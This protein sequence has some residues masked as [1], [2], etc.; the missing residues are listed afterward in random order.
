MRFHS[1][2]VR[3]HIVSVENKPYVQT[4]WLGKRKGWRG[5][6]NKALNILSSLFKTTYNIKYK[7]Q[8]RIV[9]LPYK[10]QMNSRFRK[11]RAAW[12]EAA[13]NNCILRY[14]TT[15]RTFMYACVYVGWERC[16]SVTHG[17]LELRK[18]EKMRKEGETHWR[19]IRNMHHKLVYSVYIRR[20]C[21]QW[22]IC[23]STHFCEV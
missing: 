16:Q 11:D 22:R 20:V 3:V 2:H 21:S 9:L 6:E 15:P 8:R 23:Y 1:S 10:P 14:H 5:R 17:K 4:L 7:M 19:F 18:D 12:V 13:Y